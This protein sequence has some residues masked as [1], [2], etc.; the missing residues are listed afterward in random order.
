MRM[1]IRVSRDKDDKLGG[2][3]NIFD[4]N[5]YEPSGMWKMDPS[6]F[7]DGLNLLKIK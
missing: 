6:K 5:W 2:R 7:K 4:T 3:L 1:E